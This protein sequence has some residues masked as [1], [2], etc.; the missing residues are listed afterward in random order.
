MRHEDTLARVGGDEFVI[1]CGDIQGTKAA[2]GIAQRVTQALDAPF[3]ISGTQIP[4]T[5]SV[6]VTIGGGDDDA[7][8]LLRHAD[9]AM[10]AAK[11]RSPA[12][13]EILTPGDSPRSTPR[14]A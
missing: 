3:E 7:E 10:Y 1:V 13:I 11:A 14:R 12:G 5:A 8:E 4:I 2:T 9:A 6:G